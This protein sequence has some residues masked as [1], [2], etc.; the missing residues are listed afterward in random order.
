MEDSSPQAPTTQPVQP[1]PP[2]KNKYVQKLKDLNAKKYNMEAGSDQSSCIS[3]FPHYLCI[4]VRDRFNRSEA[5]KYHADRIVHSPNDIQ[6]IRDALRTYFQT[7]S[8][9]PSIMTGTC[10]SKHEQVIH[11][12]TFFPIPPDFHW[13]VNKRLAFEGM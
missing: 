1:D 10:N 9:S 13:P 4:E 3:T 7:D 12:G 5:R 2:I 6:N 11:D 8:F